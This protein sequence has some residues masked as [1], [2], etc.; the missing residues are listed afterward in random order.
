MARPV[1]CSVCRRLIVFPRGW[2][3]TGGVM[4]KPCA[5]KRARQKAAAA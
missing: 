3:A 5:V 1:K 2:R 4:H